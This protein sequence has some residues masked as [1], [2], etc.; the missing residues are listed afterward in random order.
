MNSST[1]PV[2][3]YSTKLEQA[4]A[5]VAAFNENLS[6]DKFPAG[7]L[8][9]AIQSELG[10]IN[11]QALRLCSIEDLAGLNLHPRRD[12][13]GVPCLHLPKL[14]IKQ[15]VQI[16]QGTDE[17]KER[18]GYVS[19]RQVERMSFEQLLGY[20]NPDEENPVSA[21]LKELSKGQQ[22]IVF[23]DGGGVDIESSTILLKE[24]RGGFKARPTGLF[25]T[26]EGYRPIYGLGANPDRTADENPLYRGRTLRPAGTCDQLNRSWAG[27]DIK[28]R[29]F[30]ALA[31]ETG[32]LKVTLD[33]AHNVL[34]QVLAETDV[35]ALLKKASV[36]YQKASVLFAERTV[37][38]TLPTLKIKMGKAAAVRSNNPMGDFTR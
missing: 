12:N 37:E 2:D 29:Q 31:V 1:A 11:D 32:E 20:Y 13:T 15:I 38:G 21:K 18:A 35:D 30:L 9:K 14:L 24:I 16:F 33:T 26:K 27:F 34:D 5:L 3:A 36:R 10:G 17:K 25:Q 8:T 19:P 28:V 6:G 7:E 4:E 22:F 23:L